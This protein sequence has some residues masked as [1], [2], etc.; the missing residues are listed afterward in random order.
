MSTPPDP[1]RPSTDRGPNATSLVLGIFIVSLVLAMG[2]MWI[3]EMRRNSRLTVQL[4][5]DGAVKTAA[6]I[7]QVRAGDFAA[8]RAA[9]SEGLK[10]RLTDAYLEELRARLE[11]LPPKPT[12]RGWTMRGG[13]SSF[14]LDL[15]GP[16]FVE[17]PS[18]FDY[19]I[20]L[21]PAPDAEPGDPGSDLAVEATY[22]S[23]RIVIDEVATREPLTPPAAPRAPVA[24]QAPVAPTAPQAPR[25]GVP[26]PAPAPA[27]RFGPR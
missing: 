1:A 4:V 15:G 3:N 10:P 13:R 27:F 12:V 17:T 5:T 24:P 16:R 11:P 18:R 25:P 14:T 23:E 2:I 22:E 9:A 19:R 6:W 7:D 21:P 20:V 8:A 26:A